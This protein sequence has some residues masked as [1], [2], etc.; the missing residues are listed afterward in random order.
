MDHNSVGT[1]YHSTKDNYELISDIVGRIHYF[2]E[3]IIKNTKNIIYQ[4]CTS[5]NFED[6]FCIHHHQEKNLQHSWGIDFHSISSSHIFHFSIYFLNNFNL[7]NMIIFLQLR[8]TDSTWNEY[9][10]YEFPSALFFNLNR[11]EYINYRLFR[12]YWYLSVNSILVKFTPCCWNE[13]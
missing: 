1:Y 8:Y 7:L 11:T 3:R 12:G 5:Y 4:K 9:L 6:N 10:T 2:S 13:H